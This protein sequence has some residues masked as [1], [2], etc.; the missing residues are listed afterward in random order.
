MD[1]GV[2]VRAEVGEH[3]QSVVLVGGLTHGGEHD[4][5]RRDATQHQVADFSGAQH[6]LEV[7]ARERAHAALGHHHI[8]ALRR[9]HRSRVDDESWL[10]LFEPAE[11]LIVRAHLG[12][13]GAEADHDVN[14][15]NGVA[16]RRAYG[17][18]STREEGC[19]IRHAIDDSRLDVHHEER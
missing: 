11:G 6:D 16:A 15:R 18:S 14:H 4:P 3:R 7:A 5:T 9:D 17:F 13:A 12:H 8:A 2:R 1:L 19:G 10:L